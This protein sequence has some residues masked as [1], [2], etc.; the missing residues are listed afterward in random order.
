M[1]SVRI[2]LCRT[3][4]ERDALLHFLSERGFSATSEQRDVMVNI[5]D[6]VNLTYGWASATFEGYG[7]W[8]PQEQAEGAIAALKEWEHAQRLSLVGEPESADEK[9]FRRFLLCAFFGMM[10]PLLMHALAFYWLFQ[11]GS[12]PRRR[13]VA[14]LFGV[15]LAGSGLVGWFVVGRSSLSAFLG[16]V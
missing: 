14:T 8:V 7:L 10:L 9:N 5:S 1:K 13:P 16:F 15:L 2:R 6:T 3:V 4:I 11:S 12:V